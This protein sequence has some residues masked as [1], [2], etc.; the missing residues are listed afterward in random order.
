ML[1]VSLSSFVSSGRRG[2]WQGERLAERADRVDHGGS[3]L[4]PAEAVDHDVA[5]T[6]PVGVADAGV[7]PSSPTMA[8]LWS[9]MAR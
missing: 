8:T 1:T 6:G 2:K 4:S 5:D 3:R 9:S 7:D